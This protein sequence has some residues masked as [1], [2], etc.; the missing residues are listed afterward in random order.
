MDI[1][2]DGVDRQ[3]AACCPQEE[4][5]TLLLP[6]MGTSGRYLSSDVQGV[7]SWLDVKQK[8]GSISQCWEL[9]YQSRRL[10]ASMYRAQ[11]MVDMKIRKWKRT[12][13]LR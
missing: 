3:R 9:A 8:L 2:S 4:R 13:N 6:S 1:F 11:A 7:L 10:A 5:W 12:S